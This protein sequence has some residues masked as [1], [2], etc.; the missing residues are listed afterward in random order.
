VRIFASFA[1]LIFSVFAQ[2]LLAFTIEGT[3]FE[4]GTNIPIRQ[5]PVFYLSKDAEAKIKSTKRTETNEM[6][7]FKFEEIADEDFQIVVNKSNYKKLEFKGFN[8][9]KPTLKLTLYLERESYLEFETKIIG[10]KKK[11]DQSQKTLRQEEFLTMPGSGG[12]PVKAVQNLPGVNRVAG[13]SSQV[14]IQG[15]APGDTDYNIDGHRVPTIF[16]FGGLT[17]V[18]MPEAVE[19]VDYLSA[20]YGPENSRAL[21]GVISLKTKTPDVKERNKKGFFF[22][23]TLKSG[24]QIEGKIDDSSSYLISGRYSYVGLFLRQALKGND[25]IDLTVAPE[26]S[27]VTGIYSKKIN[28][29]DD[30]KIVALASRDTLEFLLKE[31]VREDPSLRGTF[32]NET[33]FYRLIPQWTRKV[34]T[35]RTAKLSA[36]IGRDQIIVDI[37]ENYFKLN[38][39]LLT[40]RGEWEQEMNSYWKAHWGFD[41]QYY[42]SNVDLKLP[43]FRSEGGVSNPL[44]TG[45]VRKVSVQ[46]QIRNVGNYWRN[47]VTFENSKWTLLPAIRHDR[48]SLSDQDL[49]SPRMAARY[50]WDESLQLKAATG[51]YY[52]PPQP[53]E[54]NSLV[55]NPNV[56]A[57]KALHYT[58]GFEKDFKENADQGFIWSGSYFDR[59]FSQLVIQ[60]SDYVYRNGTLQAE[61]Y[62][63]NGRGRAWGLETLL[64]ADLKP[65]SGWLGYTYTQSTRSN[66][67]TPEYRS[68]YDQT[69][70]INLLASRDLPRNWK[71]SGR[72]RYVTGNPTTPVMG[73]TFDADNDV[74]IPTRGPIYSER[75]RDFRQMDLRIDKKWILD[76][77]IWSL[78]LDMQNILGDRNPEA[79][80]YSFDYSAKEEITGLPFI[81]ALGIKGEF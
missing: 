17:S 7:E 45:E 72:Y 25:R 35:S 67:S 64:K 10:E 77:E 9:N 55:G 81:F 44:V 61:V 4:K 23:D 24:G 70:N 63:N 2:D 71:M 41:N 78:Y 14:V 29:R 13:F 56:K 26:F 73:S 43:L 28:E 46:S 1:F 32:Y 68:Q 21:G 57:P 15:S 74:Y 12:D 76:T 79:I 59:R 40:T 30:L 48:F 18:V 80:R 75:L 37:G 31:P 53:Q 42:W 33:T 22:I 65:W 19:Q 3:L 6:G 62:N 5:T 66:P 50:Q 38:S 8:K 49:F 69:H 16:H 36:G 51:L 34:D 54:V 27:D 47:E 11:R 39:T 20:G 60:S 52:Q 58:F